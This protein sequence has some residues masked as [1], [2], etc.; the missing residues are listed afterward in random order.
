MH[1]AVDSTLDQHVR[2]R[3]AMAANTSLSDARRLFGWLNVRPSLSADAVLFDHDVLGHKIVPTGVWSSA[4]TTNTTFYGTFRPHLGAVEGI[5]AGCVAAVGIPSAERATEL[6]YVVAETRLDSA[7]QPQLRER[8][9]D[10]LRLRGI[11]VDHVLLVPAGSVPKT[12]SGKVRRGEIA[13]AVQDR[14]IA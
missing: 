9:R 14:S 5:R 7:D 1:S 10:A 6:V 3:R 11:A 4:L 12:T 13:R 2:T 8:V